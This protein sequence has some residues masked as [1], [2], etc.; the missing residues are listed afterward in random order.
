M[1]TKKTRHI[2]TV[3]EA[4]KFTPVGRSFVAVIGID[5]YAHLP[6]LSNAVGDAVG[7]RDLFVN[8]FGFT[9]AG[10]LFN[11]DA[12][13]EAIWSLVEDTLRKMI[14]PDDALILFFAGHGQTRVDV[15]GKNEKE[16]GFL[17]PVEAH[18]DKWSELIG[19][20]SLLESVGTLAAR[21]L[22]VIFDACK[23]GIALGNAMQ[24]FRG[25]KEYEQDLAGRMSRKIMTS[26]QRD[27]LALDSGPVAG[28]S[29]FTGT[30][31]E[32]LNWGKADWDG[33]GIV[34]GSELALFV[35]QQVG[36][37]SKSEQTPDFGEFGLDDRGELVI[38]LKDDSFDAVKARAFAA[39]RR[40]DMKTFRTLA[41]QAA[42]AKPDSPEALY[43][44]YR[45][46]MHDNDYDRILQFVGR[47]KQI[48]LD[49]GT[50]PLSNDDLW[51]LEIQLPYWQELLAIPDGNFVPTIEI[52][53]GQ[54]IA[55]QNPL[56]IGTVDERVGYRIHQGSLYSFRI[57]NPSDKP[58]YIYLLRLDTDGR[59][60]YDSLWDDDTLLVRGLLPGVSADSYPF[61]TGAP[62][63]NELRFFA[64]ETMVPK[65][66]SPP[67]V[68]TRGLL[69][70]FG[71]TAGITRQT[72]L[73]VV[74]PKELTIS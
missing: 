51:E 5:N 2:G 36:Q 50:I 30:L 4:G 38:S 56:Q 3:E 31:I 73:H 61:A 48:P 6:K 49:K 20:N 45:S 43:L 23:S 66:L 57:T 64:S 37:Y 52:R 17:V 22:L 39:L 67:Q 9:M 54:K 72:Y 68:A 10:E 70:P 46:A 71:A 32:G 26:A 28:H 25:V 34:T 29:L 14:E 27:Q 59:F 19:I 60:R 62:G 13:K 7:L 8:K 41:E 40:G 58:L 15:V 33:N 16:T 11:V 21:H 12:T 47:L 44:G 1:A 55:H 42:K 18:P 69:T 53:S 24:K 35:Q 63:I 65:L 74:M